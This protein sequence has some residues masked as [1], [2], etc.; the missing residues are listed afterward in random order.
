MPVMPEKRDQAGR[1]LTPRRPCPPTGFKDTPE[2]DKFT[3]NC[4]RV[5]LEICPQTQRDH[6][7]ASIQFICDIRQSTLK[8]CF[9]TENL[10]C[11]KG[12]YSEFFAYSKKEGRYQASIPTMANLRTTTRLSVPISTISSMR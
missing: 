1:G 12:N 6:Y 11:K 9:P 7:H 3:M 4:M 5:G 2:F 10:N 8:Q